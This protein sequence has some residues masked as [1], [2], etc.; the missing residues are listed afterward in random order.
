V[1]DIVAYLAL[2]NSGISMATS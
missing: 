1:K 2:A